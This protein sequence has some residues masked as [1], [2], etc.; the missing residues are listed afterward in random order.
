M[1]EG[2][3]FERLKNVCSWLEDDTSK[4]VFLA[5]INYMITGDVKYIDFLVRKYL[6]QIP[7]RNG[8]EISNLLAKIP[9]EE[10]IVLYGAGTDL[11]MNIGELKKDPR[12]MAICDADKEKQ[13]M[14][15]HGYPV[16]SPEALI[17]TSE[18]S[19]IITSHVALQSIRGYLSGHHYPESKIYELAPYIFCADYGQYFSPDF[20]KY[21]T[22]G[23]EVFIDDGCCDLQS[24]ML[25]RKYCSNIRKVYAFEPD[26]A[27][28]LTCEQKKKKYRLDQVELIRKGTWSKTERLSFSATND[29]SSHLT[30]HGDSYIDVVAIDDVVPPEEKI[31]LIK[32]DVEGA[33][34]ES[35]KGA[36][37]C[38]I[39]NKPKLAICIYHKTEDMLELPEYIK[40]IAPEYKLYL[41]HHSNTDGETVLYAVT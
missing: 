21:D 7:V 2:Q 6:P 29:G 22:E 24:T 38:I 36:K 11:E 39:R 15:L 4:E 16:I 3:L 35:L 9:H 1:T 13:T 14:M 18:N 32:M 12:I 23:G 41:R 20:M 8:L 40:S 30:N 10:K 33:E 37:K 19:V 25:L 26:P 28:Y 31:S 34:L 5:R 27:N 17:S